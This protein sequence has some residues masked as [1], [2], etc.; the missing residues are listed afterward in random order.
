[1]VL[2][3]NGK[4]VWRHI[5]YLLWVLVLGFFVVPFVV[6]LSFTALPFTLVVALTISA[7]FASGAIT[8]TKSPKPQGFWVRYWPMLL[9]T[10][11]PGVAVSVGMLMAQGSTRGFWAVSAIL[12]PGFSIGLIAEAL[13]H[14]IVFSPLAPV[15][16]G[17]AY[18]A[19]FLRYE[20]RMPN[21]ATLPRWLF[22]LA[23]VLAVAVLASGAFFYWQRTLYYVPKSH[24]FAYERGYSSVD[25]SPY[26]PGNPENILPRLSRPASFRIEQEADMPVLD[27]AEAAYPVYAAF[28][29]NCYALALA[30]QATS[31]QG[32][33]EAASAPAAKQPEPFDRVVT[34]TNTI[35]AYERLLRGKV[36]IFFG[37]EPSVAQRA[38]AAEKGVELVLTPIGNEA[39]VFF[40]SRENPLTSLTQEQIR[41]IYSGKL[42]NWKDLG[43]ADARIWAFQRPEGSGSQTIMEKFMGTVPL[44]QPLQE[45]RVGGMGG[46][47]EQTASY[48]NVPGAVGYSFRFF[49]T[50][51]YKGEAPPLLALEGVAPTPEHISNGTYPW[52]VPLYAITLKNNPKPT[53]A[54]FVRWMQGPEGQE[55]VE[56]VGYSRYK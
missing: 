18:S 8:G 33:G 55:L 21:P 41:A 52:V 26:K 9:F 30:P 50:S 49:A 6:S 11:V 31:G 17:F 56:A 28:A 25:L 22:P 36:D 51:M 40:V 14:G 15:V 44:V 54:A 5:T 24:G 2:H 43:G 23:A 45:E 37:A 47:M 42:H 38:L 7:G 35:N 39:F 10:V 12:S 16:Y 20:Q 32:E 3:W 48:R 13:W 34:F 4:T 46:I 29:K 1:M 19:G 27:G 53:V